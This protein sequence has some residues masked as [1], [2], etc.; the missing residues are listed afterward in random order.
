M[1]WPLGC[2]LGVLLVAGLAGAGCGGGDS[3]GDPAEAEPPPATS[4]PATST[5]PESDI[6]SVPPGADYELSELPPSLPFLFG[7]ERSA[8]PLPHG[9]GSVTDV[10]CADGV[11][12]VELEPGAEGV[13]G[14]ATPFDRDVFALRV[15]TDVVADERGAVAFGVTCGLLLDAYHLVVD[16]AGSFVILRERPGEMIPLAEGDASGAVRASGRNTIRADCVGARRDVPREAR[17]VLSINGQAVGEAIDDDPPGSFRGVV[18][19]N[20]GVSVVG[21]GEAVTVEFDDFSARQ[22]RP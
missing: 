11:Y 10:A 22:T 14:L 16:R 2:A 7:F 9:G 18:L 5:E 15:E 12:R 1:T 3:A 19:G 13:L 4:E 6:E 8:C 20:A 17:L 21:F